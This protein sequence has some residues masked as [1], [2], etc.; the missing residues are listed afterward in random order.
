M[1]TNKQHSL[2]SGQNV[3]QSVIIEGYC[4]HP[5]FYAVRHHGDQPHHVFDSYANS[6]FVSQWQQHTRV[7]ELHVSARG[8]GR[9]RIRVLMRKWSWTPK[10]LADQECN[11]G[12]DENTVDISLPNLGTYPPHSRLHIEVLPSSDSFT[13]SSLEFCTS[14]EPSDARVL[15]LVRTYNRGEDVLRLCATVHNDLR[16]T[17]PHCFFIILDSSDS[18]KKISPTDIPQDFNAGGFLVV[19]S[20]NFGSGGNISAGLVMSQHIAS[21]SATDILILDDDVGLDAEAIDRYIA[22]CRYRSSDLLISGTILSKKDPHLI[23]ESGG[24]Y[25]CPDDC[26]RVQGNLRPTL[27]RPRNH[28]AD[29]LDSGVLDFLTLP[30]QCN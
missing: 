3:L 23:Y 5:H 9:A 8:K 1:D 4:D 29:A 13:L 21:F 20:P 30:I 10:V 17:S 11:F 28:N 18:G 7:R 27:L 24:T 2:F 22:Y 26:A 12:T 6:F 15:V 19:Q 16:N 25:G 14:D